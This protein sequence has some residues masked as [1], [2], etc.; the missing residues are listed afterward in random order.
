MATDDR[1]DLEVQ[2]AINRALTAEREASSAV[3]RSE[4]EAEAL[5]ASSRERAQQIRQ[6]GA[7]RAAALHE[8]YGQLREKRIDRE[9]AKATASTP[10]VDPEEEKVRIERA[11]ARVAA[12]LTGVES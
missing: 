9:L 4:A 11:V 2:D 5:L 3:A 6:R 10:K 8:R 12:L 7:Q 1:P